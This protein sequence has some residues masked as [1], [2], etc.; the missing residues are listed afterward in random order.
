MP[1]DDMTI[2]E[3]FES[4]KGQSV[5]ERDLP[6]KHINEKLAD[7]EDHNYTCTGDGSLHVCRMCGY[8]PPYSPTQPD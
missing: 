3:Y 7:I 1:L 5:W 8:I 2:E 6:P 4:I